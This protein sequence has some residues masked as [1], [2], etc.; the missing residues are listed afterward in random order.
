MDDDWHA[1]VLT[2]DISLLNPPQWQLSLRGTKAGARQL[3]LTWQLGE[4]Q[5]LLF[6]GQIAEQPQ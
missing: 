4:Q 5:R 1:H 2:L 3:L 6:Y